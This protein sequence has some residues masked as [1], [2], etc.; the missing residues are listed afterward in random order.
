M[1][2]K[3]ISMAVVSA[4]AAGMIL[5]APAAFAEPAQDGLLR[6]AVLYDMST[7]DVA[8]TTDNYMVPMNVFD[9]LFE[10]RMVDGT[11]QVVGSL[12]TDYAVSEDGLTY[13][14]TIRDGVVFSNGSALTA[15][16]VQYTFERLLK[17]GE[18]NMDI[19]EEVVGAEAVESG[20]ADTLEGFAVADDQHF[21]VTL[22][23]PN[24]GFTAEL[25]APAMSIVDAETMESVK[26]F[27]SEPEDTIGSG[28][29]MVTE[30]KANDHYT[31]EYNPK[32]WGEEPTVS[33]V[34]V[35]VIPDA[36]TQ[37][38]MFQDG[39]LDLIDLQSLDTSIVEST[40]K[41]MYADQVVSTPKV[42]L[43]YLTFNENQKYLQDVNV[44]KAITMGI[45]VDTLIA[46]IYN[47]NAVREHGI[48]PTGI[49][50]HNDD[51][52]GFSYDPDAAKALLKEAGYKDGEVSFE[53]AL[54]SGASDGNIKLVAQFI[55][56]QL[57]EI[58]VNAVVKSYDHA[59]WLDLRGSSEMES[60]VA[61][62]GM[63]YNDPANIM[64]T[65]FGSE[66]NTKQRSLNYPDKETIERVAAAS[67][68]VDD[69]ERE[70]EYRALEE[71]I[72]GQD[73]A[74]CALFEGLHLYCI[75]DRVESFTPQWAGF[76]DF[77]AS[78]VVLK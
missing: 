57:K 47:G 48:I 15:S 71:K 8:K 40:Y 78:D 10:T 25:S 14:F 16:D 41:T 29:Y 68:I 5:Q 43:T 35:N 27:G 3:R 69:Q 51:F 13:D 50:A 61:T 59:A 37:N 60:F 1:M 32:Y 19:P 18:E 46:G 21:S 62:W 17:A 45:D 64:Y 58:G 33:K 52:E 38:L 53:I 66:K 54:D 24:A 11:A 55:S 49:W 22:T 12:C 20:E 75:G 67:G 73:C 77:Y 6:T 31:L 36:S 76:T 70:A 65:F 34:I 26:N 9:R 23:R 42:G 63:D 72:I 4:L 44:R 56:E 30:W 39:E 7:M 28:P 2:K 74:W